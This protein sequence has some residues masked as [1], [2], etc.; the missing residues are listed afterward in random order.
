MC[1]KY[2]DFPACTTA[3]N[4][5]AEPKLIGTSVAFTKELS[6]LRKLG[7]HPNIISLLNVYFIPNLSSSLLIFDHCERSL[8]DM[9]RSEDATKKLQNNVVERQSIAVQLL[10][11]LA[12]LAE[13][14]IVHRFL[15]TK[16]VLCRSTAS[17]T[18]VRIAEF[19]YAREASRSLVAD[20]ISF[21]ADF[22]APEVMLGK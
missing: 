9:F 10:R 11:A 22:I 1:V 15:R 17:G 19:G 16:S 21:C 7:S 2:F 3:T 5:S 8:Y 20:E 13:H 12:Y 14:D 6:V 18:E 4:G